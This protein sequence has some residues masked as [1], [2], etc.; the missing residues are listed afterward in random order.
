MVDGR[1]EI[2]LALNDHG[3]YPGVHYRDNTSYKM[4]KNRLGSTRNA[5]R[6]SERIISLPMHLGLSYQDVQRTSQA[7]LD[8]LA[9][10]KTSGE[11][12][13]NA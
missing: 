12:T 8:A 10:K 4:Y 6:A 13:H 9:F 2:M 1:D 11:L 3:I 7:L 5:Q